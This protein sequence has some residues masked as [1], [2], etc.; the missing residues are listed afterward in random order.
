MSGTVLFGSLLASNLN[1]NRV[2]D[3]R[4][5]LVHN[6]TNVTNNFAIIHTKITAHCHNKYTYKIIITMRGYA[7]GLRRRTRV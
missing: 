1:N 4:N 6:L 5:F 2:Y 3:H 7:N